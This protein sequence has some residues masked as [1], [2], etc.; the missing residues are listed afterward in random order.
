MSETIKKV[1]QLEVAQADLVIVDMGDGR[2]SISKNRDGV[3]GLTDIFG[4]VY[5][6]RSQAPARIIWAK[7][8]QM[9]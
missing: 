9:G 6:I 3:T 4:V 2:F 5:E 7:P 1:S 8:H